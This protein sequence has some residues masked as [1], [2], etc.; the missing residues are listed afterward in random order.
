MQNYSKQLL[1]K[2]KVYKSKTTNDLEKSSV[3]AA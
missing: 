2:G 1:S 3:V